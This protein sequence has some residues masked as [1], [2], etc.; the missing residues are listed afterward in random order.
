[1]D[2]SSV[3]NH[4]EKI[5]HL[6]MDEIPK[7]HRT[8]SKLKT[9]ESEKSEALN[10]N[11]T[12]EEAQG[13]D[14]DKIKATFNKRLAILKRACSVLPQLRGANDLASHDQLIRFG[15]IMQRY[16]A[17]SLCFCIHLFLV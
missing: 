1:M 17:L 16:L 13:A 3:S 14:E 5:E 8:Q 6:K 12:S 7:F 15:F 4:R 2:L 10:E 9:V 11:D